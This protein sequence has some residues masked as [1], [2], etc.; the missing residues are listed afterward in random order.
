[1]DYGAIGE[2]WA[3]GS[4]M[5]RAN[6][7]AQDWIDWSQKEVAHAK[8]R[9]EA[10]DA[11]RSAQIH[12]LRRALMEVAPDHEVLRETGLQH[13]DGSPEF[14]W[15]QAY[16]KY[17]DDVA[18]KR[19]IRL[20]EKAMHPREAARLAVLT[21][22]VTARRI[23]F[24]RT[25]WFRGEQYRSERGAQEARKRAAEKAALEVPYA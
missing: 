5:K 16:C 1:M 3:F 9:A 13:R 25:W 21:E 18:I 12:V 7:T 23:M 17:Y 4:V 15:E 14:K 10:I 24:C 6:Q 11:G 8:A 22:P 20:C 19:G 2:A